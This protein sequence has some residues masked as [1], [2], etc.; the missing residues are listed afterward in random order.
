MRLGEA[1]FV[2]VHH[3]ACTE[4]RFHYYIAVDGE[5]FA[6]L[7]EGTRAT[8]PGCI[9]VVIDGDFDATTPNDKQQAAL[10]ALL[11]DLKTRYPDIAVGAHRQVR[12]AETTCPG[13]RFP[14]RALLAWA[15]SDLVAE[16]DA[17]LQAEVERQ[18]RPPN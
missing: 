3:G 9:E 16:R 4:D 2:L 18:D 12:G 15:Q 1:R 8:R 14:L 17:A 5:R 11:L 13:R 7:N 6:G 10:R